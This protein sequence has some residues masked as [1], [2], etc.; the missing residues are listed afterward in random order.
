MSA[1]FE[2]VSLDYG[3]L[4]WTVSWD[5][6]HVRVQAKHPVIT[7]DAYDHKFPISPNDFHKDHRASRG[8]EL[9]RQAARTLGIKGG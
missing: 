6:K 3:G 1:I 8:A 9:I 4:R 7:G 2:P 5:N